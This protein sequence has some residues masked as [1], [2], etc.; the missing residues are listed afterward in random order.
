[1]QP[2]ILFLVILF[3]LVDGINSQTVLKAVSPESEGLS[4]GRLNRLDVNIE[5]WI[6][7][8]QL[9]GAAAIILR[10]G[11]IVYHKAFGFANKQ[12]NVPMKVDNIFRIASMTKPVISVAAMMLYEEGKFLLSDPLSKFIPEFKNP[13]VLDKY[14]AADTTFT[15]VPAKREITIRE[16][17]RASCREK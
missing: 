10:N 8:D 11:K 15:T 9:N 12:R 4:S 6:K 3:V 1:M 5:Q 16:I 14:N 2:L 17:G 7:E 13:V